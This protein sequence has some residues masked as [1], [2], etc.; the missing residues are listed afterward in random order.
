MLSDACPKEVSSCPLK[1]ESLGRSTRWTDWNVLED[2]RWQDPLLKTL[3]NIVE[4]VRVEKRMSAA[5]RGAKENLARIADILFGGDG[6]KEHAR[7][8]QPAALAASWLLFSLR[9]KAQPSLEKGASVLGDLLDA[10]VPGVRPAMQSVLD[11][12][13]EPECTADA[14]AIGICHLKTAPLNN[15]LS[16]KAAF[17]EKLK[18]V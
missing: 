6:W 17:L 11:H 10:T 18:D 5:F 16:V 13:F 15:M 8:S 9:S 12:A 1:A 7:P 14:A 2:G 4:D 3:L